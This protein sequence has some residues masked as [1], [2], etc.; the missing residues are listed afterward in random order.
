MENVL[1]ALLY[2]WESCRGKY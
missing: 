1:N 2:M